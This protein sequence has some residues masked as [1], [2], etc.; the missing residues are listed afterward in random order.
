MN[1][2][3]FVALDPPELV[4]RRLAALQ[5]E[6][7][8]AAGRAAGEVRWV[9]VDGVHLTLQFLGG[10]PEERVEAVSAALAA[11]ASESKPLHLEL[12]G[13]GG[14]PTARRARV[15]WA[16]V[17]G[18]VAPLA[19]LVAALGRRLAPLGYAPEERPFHPHLT[20]GRARDPHGAPGLAAALATA[21]AAPGAPWRAGE[22]VL[23]QSH[24]SP[25]GPRY[26]AL[27]R[28]P[29]GGAPA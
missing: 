15:V 27:A 2:R 20:V 5:A 22:L 21:G 17:G 18:D 25:Q 24:L 29:L 7:R 1:L 9:A 8:R 11:A 26:E 13:A 16:G 4:R 6:L 12:R 19:E 3:L 10:V 14:F 23:F 28:A